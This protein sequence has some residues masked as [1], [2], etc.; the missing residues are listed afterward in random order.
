MIPKPPTVQARAQV[1]A[2]TALNF[3]IGHRWSLPVR[4]FWGC[5]RRSHDSYRFEDSRLLVQI[6]HCRFR[7]VA[8]TTP[9]LVQLVGAVEFEP[10][11]FGRAMIGALDPKRCRDWA[12]E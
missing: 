2:Q 8:S 7:R 11:H 3:G 5:H 6:Y 1:E 12:I 9:Y 10:I 4:H